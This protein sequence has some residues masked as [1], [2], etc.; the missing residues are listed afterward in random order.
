MALIV[1]IVGQLHLFSFC[2]TILFREL[3]LLP[4]QPFELGLGMKPRRIPIGKK[5]L[6]VQ[7]DI[8][9][10]EIRI[11]GNC[12]YKIG[13][14]VRSCYIA[15]VKHEIFYRGPLVTFWL[16]RVQVVFSAFPV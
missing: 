11:D 14:K 13:D 10:R 4:G 8:E 3:H 12:H 16:D 9:N 2:C 15:G 7:A 6:L 5:R 1:V